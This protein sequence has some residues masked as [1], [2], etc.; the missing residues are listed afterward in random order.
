MADSDK[1]SE[2]QIRTKDPDNRP[3]LQIR[4]TDPDNRYIRLQ[5][6][7]TDLITDPITDLD[8]SIV[9]VKPNSEK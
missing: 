4:N 9:F 7:I 3:R 1:R 6:R 5:I 8:D 2:W